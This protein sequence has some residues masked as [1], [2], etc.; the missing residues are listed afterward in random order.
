MSHKR[1]KVSHGFSTHAD[2]GGE[3][4]TLTDEGK[5]RFLVVLANPPKANDLLT[6]LMER[7]LREVTSRP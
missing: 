3:K 5:D 6:D 7:Y 4:I 2:N 1:F